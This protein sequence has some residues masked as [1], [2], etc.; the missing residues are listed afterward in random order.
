MSASST[1]RLFRRTVL[2]VGLAGTSSCGSAPRRV[3]LP[4]PFSA[5]GGSRPATPQGVQAFGEFG[6]GVWGQ[7]QE[8]VEIGGGGVLALLCGTGSS[9]ASRATQPRVV[10]LMPRP[11]S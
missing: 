7:E 1:W 4:V 9:S 3:P 6:D 2:V 11:P 10:N 5:V 8:R